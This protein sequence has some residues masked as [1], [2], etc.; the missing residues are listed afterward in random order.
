MSLE[1]GFKLA[2]TIDEDATYEDIIRV[3]SEIGGK[4]R[5]GTTLDEALQDLFKDSIE[6]GI[7]E[8][9][10]EKALDA[11][12]PSDADVKEDDFKNLN[13][14]FL[15]N[16]DK[17][18]VEDTPFADYSPELAKNAEG[19]AE[20]TEGILRYNDAVQSIDKNLEDW[21]TALNETN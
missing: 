5:E 7:D 9:D 14:T 6:E 1:D 18:G 21:K 16:T 13:D 17:F 3:L 15:E 20:V 8:A 11:M 12:K 2:A 4:L 10:I 19:L